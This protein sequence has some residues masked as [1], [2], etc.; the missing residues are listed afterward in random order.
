MSDGKLEEARWWRFG[1]WALLPCVI[2]CCLYFFVMSDPSPFPDSG[3]YVKLAEN[4]FVKQ[5]FVN[6]DEDVS[7]I[8]S[9]VRTPGYPAMIALFIPVFGNHAF[10]VVNVLCLYG[11]TLITMMLF[12]RLSGS[13]AVMIPILITLS[14]GMIALSTVPLTELPFC[15][16]LLTCL[17]LISMQR[18]A[19]SG[20][21]MAIAT[22]VRPAGIF[23]FLPI[24]LWMLVSRRKWHNI[25]VFVLLAN[26]L[27][28]LWSLRNYNQCGYF[29]FSTISGETLLHYKAGSL[30][31]WRDNIPFDHVRDDLSAR[32]PSNGNP[33]ER[34]REASRLGRRILLDNFGW[35]CLWAPRDLLNFF[36]PDINP[37]LERLN[38]STGN[39]GTLDVLRRQGVWKAF[40]HYFSGSSLAARML[41]VVY[42]GLYALSLLLLPLGLW[43]LSKGM[44]IGSPLI[45]VLLSVLYFWVI[46]LGNLDWRFR[47]P[48]TPLLFIFIAAGYARMECVLKRWKCNG[49]LSDEAVPGKN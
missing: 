12:R 37:L 11:L 7:G 26:S 40:R 35:F 30:L 20:L 47:M 8:N 18:F 21:C 33:V 4:L 27:P 9:L 22:L 19:A 44:G 49:V 13:G 28:L 43:S 10:F 29:V 25:L 39:R 45:P 16:W 42:V 41:F 32:L 14:P 5:R 24:T 48:V 3:E 2:A 34:G 46:P 31:S 23:L 6:S 17:Y 36:M 38:L 15:L 1:V